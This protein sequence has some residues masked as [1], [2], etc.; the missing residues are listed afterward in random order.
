MLQA[1]EF[2]PQTVSFKGVGVFQQIVAR[3]VAENW[4]ALPMWLNIPWLAFE[5]QNHT[6]WFESCRGDLPELL[7]GDHDV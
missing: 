5:Y 6:I 7:L 2:L 1:A 3:A 4:A